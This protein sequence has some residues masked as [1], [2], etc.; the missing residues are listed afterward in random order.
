M[1][2]FFDFFANGWRLIISFNK[3]PQMLLLSPDKAD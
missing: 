1:L 3:A 2:A